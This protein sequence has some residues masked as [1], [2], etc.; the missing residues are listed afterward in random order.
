M[1]G[2]PGNRVLPE[3]YDK[4]KKTEKYL[5]TKSLFK[6]LQFFCS[7]EKKRTTF[8]HV[9]DRV[10]DSTCSNRYLL[11]FTARTLR[12]FVFKILRMYDFK[13]NLLTNNTFGTYLH[14]KIILTV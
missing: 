2:L 13:Q 3:N 12:R 7:E 9:R 11:E 6:E 14:F 10:V 4:A 1:L 8:M 5:K